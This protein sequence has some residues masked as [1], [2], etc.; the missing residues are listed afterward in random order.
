MGHNQD[1]TRELQQLFNAIDI[2]NNPKPVELLM[3]ILNIA[4]DKDSI[5]LDFF[6][7]SG[8]TAQAAL[9]LNAHDDANRNFVLVQL[10]EPTERTEFPT[11]TD[12]TEQTGQPLH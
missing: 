1:A 12:K 3:T 10:P 6:G 11:H 8:T 7:G 5:I 2:F 4:A 9:E